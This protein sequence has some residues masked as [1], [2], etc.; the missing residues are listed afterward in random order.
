[1]KIISHRGNLKGVVPNKENR[2]S[3]IDSAIGSGYEVEV[4]IRYINGEFWLGHDTPDYKI[5]KHWILN[6]IND[7]W[8]HCKNL[9]A[10]IELKKL[11]RDIKY[12]CHLQDSYIITSTNHFWVHDL[13]L[14]LD[15]N[16]IIPLLDEE[17]VLKFNDKIVY[18][19]CTDYVDLCKFSLKNKGLY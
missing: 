6:R 4:D 3:Y 2:P 18:A 15:E 9:D 14:K 8:Y 10:A 16:C 7:I 19:V 1:M 17:S 12:F 11:N 5:N 13:S